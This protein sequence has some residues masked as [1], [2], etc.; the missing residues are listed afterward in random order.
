MPPVATL[1]L[2]PAVDKN[3]RVERV[4]A[5]DKLRCDAPHREPSRGGINGARVIHRLGG[6]ARALYALGG[7]AGYGDP[8]PPPG[9]GPHRYFF[10]LYVLDTVLDLDQG[11][12]EEQVADAMDGNVIDETDRTGTCER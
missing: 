10:R 7:D 5:N 11:A 4:V 6:D 1:P 9:D 12:P 3:T 8:C 2:N